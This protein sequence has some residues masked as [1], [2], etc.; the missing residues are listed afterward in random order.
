MTPEATLNVET[1]QFAYFATVSVEDL[2]EIPEPG[3]LVSTPVREQHVG[4]S[5]YLNQVL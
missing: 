3:A 1:N 5:G 2:K 4:Q